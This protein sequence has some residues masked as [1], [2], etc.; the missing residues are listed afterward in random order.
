MLK[1]ISDDIY[2]DTAVIKKSTYQSV[3][4]AFEAGEIELGHE[5]AVSIL[6]AIFTGQISSNNLTVKVALNTDRALWGREKADWD[7][8]AEAKREQRAE[9][10]QLETIVELKRQGMTQKQIGERLGVS[11]QAIGKRLTIMQTEYP[12]LYNQ[13]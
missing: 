7:K 3:L 13:I 10:L 1:Q 8:K 12:E 9:E 2:R 11:Q 4:D 6:E 5:L